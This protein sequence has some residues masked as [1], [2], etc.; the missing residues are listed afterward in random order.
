MIKIIAHK[1]KGG[2]KFGKFGK[3][4]R[5]KDAK[6]KHRNRQE[7]Y[8]QADIGGRKTMT[9]TGIK[10]GIIC[11]NKKCGY[12]LSDRCIFPQRA[13]CLNISENGMCENFVEKEKCQREVSELFGQ[14]RAEILADNNLYNALVS[15]IES[16]IKELPPRID[17]EC[18]A[19]RIADRIIGRE[20]D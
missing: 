10:L 7:R 1:V 13:F 3:T 4:Y 6:K 16:A 2:Y 9:D 11:K 5:R 15:S 18:A 19:K 8:M 17:R 14:I 12:C 20:N